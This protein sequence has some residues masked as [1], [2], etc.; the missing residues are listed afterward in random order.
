M[1]DKKYRSVP[2]GPTA[3]FGAEKVAEPKP[4]KVEVVERLT[5]LDKSF[6]DL[7]KARRETALA[8][9]KT[10]LAQSEISELSYNNAI[11]QLAIRYRLAD[12][13]II[14]EDGSITRKIRE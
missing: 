12:G 8:N 11:L 10:A 6:L 9:A 1:K 14:N 7:A 5:D 4:L 2:T 13:D 3:I